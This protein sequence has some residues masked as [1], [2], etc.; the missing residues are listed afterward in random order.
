MIGEQNDDCDS[1]TN[2]SM[3]KALSNVKSFA[4]SNLQN[5][6][7]NP[8]PYVYMERNVKSAI[9]WINYFAFSF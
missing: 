8:I 6:G 5:L 9:K 1:Q 7:Y 3:S 2:N 4:S